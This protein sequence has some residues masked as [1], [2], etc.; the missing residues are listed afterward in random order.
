[1]MMP[2]WFIVPAA[3]ACVGALTLICFVL[4]GAW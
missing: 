4:V 2:P 1:M 3:I